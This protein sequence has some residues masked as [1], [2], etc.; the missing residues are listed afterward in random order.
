MSW[1][2]KVKVP[3][4]EEGGEILTP[5]L[6]QILVGADEDQVLLYQDE[7]NNWTEKA[8]NP[9]GDWSFKPKVTT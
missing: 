9:E 6:H 4:Q 2:H 3:Q 7:F 8:R 1:I 5:D